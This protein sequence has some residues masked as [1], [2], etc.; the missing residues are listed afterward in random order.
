MSQSE[1]AKYDLVLIT[2]FEEAERPV[3]GTIIELNKR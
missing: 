3:T 2:D 1:R